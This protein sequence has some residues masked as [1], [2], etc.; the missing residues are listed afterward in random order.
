MQACHRMKLLLNSVDIPVESFPSAEGFLA[1]RDRFGERPEC[2]VLDLCL[3]GMNGVQLQ[4][5]LAEA[6]IDIPVILNPSML[7]CKLT[8][9]QY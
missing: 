3:P 8:R 9:I 2:L 7:Y 6:R 1:Q 4:E 5:R